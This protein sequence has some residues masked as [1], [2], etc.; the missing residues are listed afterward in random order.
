MKTEKNSVRLR[1]I[2]C[3]Y[4][5]T[6]ETIYRIG[7]K[8]NI[9]TITPKNNNLAHQSIKLFLPDKRDYIQQRIIVIKNFYEDDILR[10]METY[11]DQNS[12]VIDIGSN[13]GNHVLYFGKILNAKKIYAFEPQKEVF[14]ILKRNVELNELTNKV[15]IYNLALGSKTSSATIDYD[16]GL[17]N[18]LGMTSIKEDENGLLKIEK[19][20]DVIIDVKKINFIKIDV[21]GFESDVLKGASL[22]IQKYKPTIWIE[23]FGENYIKTKEFLVDKGYVLKKEFPDFNYLFVPA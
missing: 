23:S 3:L 6:L 11:I 17:C 7:N 20:D 19:L 22:T 5:N 10:A 18:N 12:V 8:D 13:I 9:F 4:I 15:N 14:N 21:E 1:K 16:G 2:L